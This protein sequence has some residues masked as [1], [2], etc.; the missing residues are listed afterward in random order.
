MSRLIAQV[1]TAVIVKGVRTVI[2]AGDPL[3]DDLPE[4]DKRELQAAR[5]AEPEDADA[6]AAAESEKAEAKGRAR[7][8][9]ERKAVQAAQAS[10]APAAPAE[11]VAANDA[12]TDAEVTGDG[13]GEALPPISDADPVTE[14]SE[15]KA[16]KLTRRTK[17]QP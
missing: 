3:P 17:V 2:P 15:A 1:A 9:A 10:I 11:P 4:H 6:K 5:L 8:Q 13:S 12:A 14:P 16:T 7:Y